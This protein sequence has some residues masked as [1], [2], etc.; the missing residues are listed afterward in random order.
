M[1]VQEPLPSQRR[2]RPEAGLLVVWALASPEAAAAVVAQALADDSVPIVAK[3][4]VLPL[5]LE[6]AAPEILRLTL[7][8]VLILARLQLLQLQMSLAHLFAKLHGRNWGTPRSMVRNGQK[9]PCGAMHN[10]VCRNT[11]RLHMPKR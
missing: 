10:T 7:P 3:H 11:A 2:A 9:S 6:R 8:K 1:Q 4:S 5:L